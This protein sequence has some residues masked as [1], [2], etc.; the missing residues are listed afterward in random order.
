LPT[1]I[2]ELSKR[3]P[4]IDPSTWQE[5]FELGGVY[6]AGKP[7]T[8]FDPIVLPCRLEYYEPRF[9][10]AKAAEF[11]PQFD[12]SMIIAM[13]QDVGVA[14]KPAGLPTTPSRDQGRYNLQSYLSVHLGE[15]VHTP[16]RLDTGVP[17]L[18]LFTRSA[19]MNR[20]LQ[21][22]YEQ[23]RIHKAY[24]AMLP[25][26]SDWHDYDVVHRLARDERHP[27]LRRAVQEGGESAHTR[28]STLFEDR[29]ES[30]VLAE[31]LTGRTHQIRVHCAAE[32]RPIKGD[33][34]YGGVHDPHLHLVSFGLRFFHPFTQEYKTYLLPRQWWPEWLKQ[35]EARCGSLP[36]RLCA[37]REHFSGRE[38]KWAPST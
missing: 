8:A 13:D 37:V 32:G 26:I 34:Y 17:G 15:P 6:L 38:T 3:L 1:C 21:K 35:V 30:L 27:V 4:H 9:D 23:K 16:S 2:E 12:P 5:R 24:V 10:I 22:A 18:L 29:A 25:G 11:F 31:P 28:F 19:R 33:P 36:E 14:I 20:A 7:A